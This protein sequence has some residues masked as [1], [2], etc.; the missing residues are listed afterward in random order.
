MG[1]SLFLPAAAAWVCY[2]LSHVVLRDSSLA[3]A[4]QETASGAAS[5][6]E[7]ASDDEDENEHEEDDENDAAEEDDEHDAAEC[8]EDAPH[9][10]ISSAEPLLFLEDTG[11]I[12]LFSLEGGSDC[13]EPASG[14]KRRRV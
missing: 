12:D 6:D 7:V 11:A 3:E 9:D 8:A 10:A 14:S 13:A 4:L 5:A 1:N 2:V